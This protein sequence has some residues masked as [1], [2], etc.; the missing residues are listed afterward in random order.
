MVGVASSGTADQRSQS[1][2]ALCLGELIADIYHP[3]EMLFF[4]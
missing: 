1:E 4:V 2:L 3:P